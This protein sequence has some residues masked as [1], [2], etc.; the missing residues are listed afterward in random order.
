MNDSFLDDLRLL[1]GFLLTSAH[2]LYGE[3]KG[4]GPFRLMDAAA[5][6]LAAMEKQGMA[7]APLIELREKIDKERFGHSSDAELQAFLNE[8]CL[9]YARYLSDMF[10]PEG[11]ESAE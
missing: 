8:L 4:Y 7:D 1:V 5:R 2:G 10:P 3:P 6:L 9:E 11:T